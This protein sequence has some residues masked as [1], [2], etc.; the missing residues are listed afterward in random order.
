M[1][2]ERESAF[3][4]ERE[5]ERE[6]DIESEFDRERNSQSLKEKE[7]E[8]VGSNL[9]LRPRV[10]KKIKR[11]ILQM[12]LSRPKQRSSIKMSKTLTENKYF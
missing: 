6:S 9:I 12:C 4:R 10:C 2:R 8:R 5:S 1:C 3:D 11:E 7:R